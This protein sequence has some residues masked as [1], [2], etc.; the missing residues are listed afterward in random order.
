MQ[1]QDACPASEE[2]G[3]SG[4]GIV[5]GRS[6]SYEEIYQDP[7]KWPR[8]WRSNKDLIED[9]DWVLAGWELTIPR[10]Y[11]YAYKVNQDDWLGKIAGY[12]EIYGDYRKWTA[13]LRGESRTGS[14]IRTSSSRARSS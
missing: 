4:T 12:W 10:D 5:S 13:H 7:L 2:T 9:P 11:P 14:R 6:L 3:S 8:I 1:L